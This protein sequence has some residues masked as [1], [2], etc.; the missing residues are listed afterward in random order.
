M[1]KNKI[2]F[3]L[4]IPPPVHGSSM[5]GKY[6]KESSVVNS[7]FFTQYI[8]L[9]TSTSIKD[10]GKKPF[11]KIFAYLSII[12]HVI[13]KLFFFRPK[14]V[15]IAITAKGIGFY[16]DA[17]IV[18]LLKIFK[19]PLIYH[20]HNKGV[21][22]RQNI[23]IDNL[24][25]KIVFKD[26]KVILL[27]DFLYA[28]IK[29]YVSK[30]DVHFCPN[31][32][33][34]ISYLPQKNLNNKND[35]QLL[36]LSNLIESKGVFVLLRALEIL[37]KKGM[38]FTCNFV[39]GEG[40]ISEKDFVGRIKKM[41]LEKNVKYLGKKFNDEKFKILSSSK[42]FILPTFYENECFPLVLLE[43]MQFKLPIISTFEGGIPEIVSDGING[44]LVKQNDAMQLSHKIEL[45]INNDEL[46]GKMGEAGYEKFKKNYTLN[47]FEK[48]LSEILKKCIT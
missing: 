3:I 26:C 10:I 16:K 32:I 37:V 20:F 38:R 42:V 11:K 4:H 9:G 31:G 44:F 39:G 6:I 19:I 21:S 24:L 7:N 22:T 45:L 5:V 35:V 46:R 18:L 25:Y 29:K 13:G 15:Y 1:N 30:K 40:D 28:D 34:E 14:I 36:Y 23:L 48:N 17:L 41:G 33:P 47:K 2:L 8:N 27:S 12:Y 43:A